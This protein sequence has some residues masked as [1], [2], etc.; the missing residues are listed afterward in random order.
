MKTTNDFAKIFSL[1][2]GIRGVFIPYSAS[3]VVH[4]AFTVG[5]GTRDELPDEQGMAHYIEHC[6]FKGTK[7]RKAFHII[8]RLDAVGGELNAYTTKEETCIYASFDK[9]FT[10]RAIELISDIVFHS[11]FPEKEIEREKTVII[12]EIQSYQDSPAERIFDDFE[13]TLF[14]GNPLGHNILGTE[15]SVSG[16]SRK[17][18][19]KFMERNYIPEKMTLSI[20]GN[21]TY[22]AVQKWMQKYFAVNK[23][24]KQSGTRIKPV[25]KKFNLTKSYDTYQ[26]HFVLGGKSYSL[27]STRRPAFILLNNIL[28][29]NAMNSRLN[30]AL[31]ERNGFAYNVESSYSPYIDTGLFTIYFGTDHKNLERC[32]RLVHK[33]IQHFREKKLSTRQLHMA[34]TQLKGQLAVNEENRI[35]VVL[36][37]GKSLLVFDRVYS[38]QE[39]HERIDKITAE[40]V[41]D[42]ANEL[43]HPKNLN[44]LIYTS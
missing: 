9:R 28:G 27:K 13:E 4:F 22:E 12:D 14:S 32:E 39:I 42:V 25:V 10:E 5:A 31:R 36:S 33:E 3:D 35:N 29:G 15:E 21:V 30:I 41:Q 43:F 1:Q 44:Q 26:D 17:S 24:S 20:S 38:T 37:Y 2:N 7:K 16:F 23:R 18:V 34:K 11:V 6:L 8:S 19:E 40:S